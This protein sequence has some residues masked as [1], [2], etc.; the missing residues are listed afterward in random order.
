MNDV[1][2]HCLTRIP[3]SHHL[4]ISCG[5]TFQWYTLHQTPKP[6]IFHLSPILNPIVGS[7]CVILDST[8]YLLE[9]ML[10]TPGHA[11]PTRPRSSNPLSSAM[12]ALWEEL[13]GLDK[14]PVPGSLLGLKSLK[15]VNLTNNLFQ[16]AVLDF[17]F[18]VE[19][20]LDL[21]DNSN[22]LCLSRTNECDPRVKVLLSVV[23]FFGY[24]RWFVEDW[25]GMILC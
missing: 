17:G 16:G 21:G 14:D 15:V 24:P 7:T 2:L 22:S 6:L 19:V 1:A 9:T 23:R 4:I 20:D 18:G 10:P 5:S 11:L 3:H 8:I 25:K 12:S 13:K